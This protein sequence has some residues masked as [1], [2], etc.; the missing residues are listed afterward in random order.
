MRIG[1]AIRSRRAS[2]AFANRQVR[3]QSNLSRSS[4]PYARAAG[5]AIRPPVSRAARASRT[6]GGT[7]RA[8]HSSRPGQFAFSRKGAAAAGVGVLATAVAR[9]QGPGSTAPRGRQTGMYMY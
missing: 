9:S 4:N 2:K 5:A 8:V 1:K 7:A 3:L 6:V